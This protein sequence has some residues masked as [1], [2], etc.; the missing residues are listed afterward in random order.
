VITINNAEY[1]LDDYYPAIISKDEYEALKLQVGNKGFALIVRVIQKYR[2]F[3]VLVFCT[4][5]T[6]HAIW[7]KPNQPLKTIHMLTVTS[8]HPGF[9]SRL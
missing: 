7:L 6:A 3:P 9:T 4:A 8:V 2:Y 5:H 1:I